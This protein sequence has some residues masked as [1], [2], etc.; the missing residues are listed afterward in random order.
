M[1]RTVVYFFLAIVLLGVIATP[2]LGAFAL[3]LIPLAGLGFVWRIA[4]AVETRGRPTEA[5]VR[6]KRCHLLGPGGP[7]DSFATDGLDEDEYLAEASST[8]KAA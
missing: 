1:V 5:V 8:S 3:V 2:G 7:D 4:L 6:T